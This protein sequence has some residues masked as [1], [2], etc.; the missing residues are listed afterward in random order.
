MVAVDTYTLR[1]GFE[2][3]ILN[4]LWKREGEIVDGR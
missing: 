3:Y 4:N 2:G 1:D